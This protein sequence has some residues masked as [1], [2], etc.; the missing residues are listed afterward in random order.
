VRWPL[1]GRDRELGS[2]GALLTS[3]SARGVVLVGAAGVGKTRLATEISAVATAR[4]CATEW[5][6]ASR[7]AASIPLGAFAAL[8]PGRD[9]DTAVGAELL[10]RVR[11]A[12][13]ERAGERQLVLCVDDGQLLDD[14]S[15]VLV[16]QMV[17]A[18]V[19]F[20]VI[21]LRRGEPVADALRALWKDELCTLVEL[22][23]LSR[24]EVERLLAAA[25]G[26]PV[27]GRTLSA[28]WELTRGNALFLRELVHYGLE[29]G[30]LAD[31]GR[32]WHWRGEMASGMRLAE[33]VGARLEALGSRER[34]ALEVVAVGAPL[35][36]ALLDRDETAALEALERHGVV[37]GRADGRR[38]LVDLAHPLHGEVV[39]TG[40][41]GTRLAAIQR[42]LADAVEVRGARRR[43]DLL[44][45]AAWQ[46]E[47]GASGDPALFADAARAALSALDWPLALR[48]ARAALQAG[49]GFGAELTLARS[50]SGRAAE[51]EELLARLQPRAT[52][53]AERA[54]VAIAR[55]SNLTFGL[56]RPSDADAVLLAAER[57]IADRIQRDDVVAVRAWVLCG[58]GRPQPALEAAA[59]L[60]ASDTR[61][62]TRV[63]AAMATA[64]ALAMAGRTGEAIA[65]AEATEPAGR[66][67]R[68]KLPLLSA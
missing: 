37:A 28:L 33:L 27:D 5:V 61:E 1:V 56:G 55:A 44:R 20:A 36:L 49:G 3:G 25:L 26:D 39:R 6:R 64:T 24:D 2:V 18:G 42:R 57:A 21:T 48:L 32:L 8:L 15:A 60:L 66:R 59:P 17:A 7:S 34:S 67:H 22:D 43:G 31:E 16:H 51:A 52:T 11:E 53:D 13:A 40:L 14:A 65:L 58:Q 46:L 50:L 29:R 30:V 63:R 12:L 41:S 54:A 10:A 38:R 19:A 68:G 9:A 47:S 45:L 35:E 23:E 4:G 62:Q